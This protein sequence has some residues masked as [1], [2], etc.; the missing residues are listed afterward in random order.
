MRGSGHQEAVEAKRGR[1][2]GDWQKSWGHGE[3]FGL[4]EAVELSDSKQFYVVLKGHGGPHVQLRYKS[5][6]ANQRKRG[7]CNFSINSVLKK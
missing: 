6:H 3:G 5:N 4:P 1:L 2:P 7:G